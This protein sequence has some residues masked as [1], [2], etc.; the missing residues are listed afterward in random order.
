MKKATEHVQGKEQHGFTEGHSISEATRP[1]IDACVNARMEGKPPMLLST[2][3]STAFDAITFSHIENSLKFMEFPENFIKAFMKLV[4]N[5]T[6]QVE[7]NNTTSADVQILS[8]TGQGDPKS[9][10]TFNCSVAPLNHLISN[11]SIIYPNFKPAFFAHDN[12][13]PLQG[14]KPRNP[15]NPA[16]YRSLWFIS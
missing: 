13:I 4:T 2:D 8:G 3:F 6:L 9:S 5:G 1:M 15:R 12:I 10:Y 11:S 16:I 7:F 14:D